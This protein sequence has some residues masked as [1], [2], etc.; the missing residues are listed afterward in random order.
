MAFIP[1]HVSLKAHFD[2]RFQDLAKL[3]DAR[4]SDL[5]DQVNRRVAGHER[6]VDIQ[7]EALRRELST[8]IETQKVAVDKAEVATE[9]RLE[10]L[11]EFRD[12]LRDQSSTLI[13]REV[14]EA[15]ITDLRNQIN[16]LSDRVTEVTAK[17]LGSEQTTRQFNRVNTLRVAAIAAAIA[18]L[19]IVVIVAIHFIPTGGAVILSLI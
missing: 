14:A 5:Q 7:I 16:L 4:H 2:A 8:A 17:D 3:Y 19:S 11:N 13:S 10:G 18:L 12:V 9:K 6:E 15:Q 1:D